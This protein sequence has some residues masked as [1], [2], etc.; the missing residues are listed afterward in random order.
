VIEAV[1]AH[2]GNTPFSEFVTNA[3]RAYIKDTNQ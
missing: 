1:D 3:V 2:R